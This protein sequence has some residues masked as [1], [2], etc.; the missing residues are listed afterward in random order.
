MNSKR[1]FVVYKTNEIKRSERLSRKHSFQNESIIIEDDLDDPNKS[2]TG[3][4]K[5]FKK[6]HSNETKSKKHTTPSYSAKKLNDR[7][8]VPEITV[9][10]STNN[11]DFDNALNTKLPLSAIVETEALN[12]FTKNRSK[13]LKNKLSQKSI[14]SITKSSVT[15]LNVKKDDDAVP[16]ELNEENDD[17]FVFTRKRG[18]PSL[19]KIKLQKL[20][21]IVN[22]CH[23]KVNHKK[24][25]NLSVIVKKLH[26]V[27]KSTFTKILDDNTAKVISVNAN[28]KPQQISNNLTGN[29]SSGNGE[30]E[31][32]KSCN[33]EGNINKPEV[34]VKLDERIVSTETAPV[35]AEL[36][37][38]ANDEQ[39]T[40]DLGTLERDIDLLSK[41]FA[42]PSKDIKHMVIEESISVLREKY[43]E[44]IT[45]SMITI[46]PILTY[47]FEDN[48][49]HDD[50]SY[51]IEPIRES[52]AHLK[53]NLKDLMDEL[54]KTM[55]SWSLSIVNDPPRYV[56]AQMSIDM[57]G[58]PNASKSIVLD[59]YF[60]ASVYINQSLQ[61][62]Y[63]K[64][65]E[66]AA[67][68]VKLIKVLNSEKL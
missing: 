57:Y 53:T 24:T 2:N 41:R 7:I 34:F 30:I 48:L 47:D 15:Q 45:P 63:C 6:S 58:M 23:S 29:K 40:N 26:N 9:K 28:S 37:S 38:D 20:D 18:R 32:E 21:D 12:V 42:I 27:N 64:R 39:L 11:S 54:T 8:S 4:K 60:R 1:K 61:Y 43:S 44:S 35:S 68:I 19:K 16:N 31:S 56:I 22:T 46:S 3:N 50:K 33:V 62:K 66:T 65:Y 36:L 52:T 59:R 14:S 67:E 17:S 25:E 55:T 49:V 13:T 5:R 10:N 51:K